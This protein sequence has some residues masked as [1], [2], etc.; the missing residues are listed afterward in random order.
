[1]ATTISPKFQVVIP[2]KIRESMKLRSGQKVHMIAY[3]GLI[4]IV[5]V[6]PV[7]KFIGVLKGKDI[8]LDRE[9]DPERV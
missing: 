4:E 9:D 3:D 8:S 6:Y 7:E 5:P 1:M 2:K